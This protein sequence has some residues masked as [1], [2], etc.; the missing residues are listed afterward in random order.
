MNSNIA[1]LFLLVL[2]YNCDLIHGK[3]NLMKVLDY[4]EKLKQNKQNNGDVIPAMK[5]EPALTK[6]SYKFSYVNCGPDT[7][8]LKIVSLVVSPDPL[9]I[10]GTLRFSGEVNLKSTLLSPLTMQMKLIKKIGFIELEI[11][12]VEN[13]GSCTYQDVCAMLPLPQDCPS[14][15]KDQKLPCTCPFNGG[16]YIGKN[17]EVEVD[18]P[19]KIPSGAYIIEADFHSPALGHVGCVNIV[20]NAN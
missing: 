5:L 6:P 12:C 13:F 3:Y 17:L 1:L 18:L 4:Y 10:P 9:L 8:P 20:L 19:A 16:D 11:P 7:D 2:I 15:F 14:F